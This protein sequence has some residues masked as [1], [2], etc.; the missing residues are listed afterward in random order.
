MLT[1]CCADAV[2]R[3]LDISFPFGSQTAIVG[4]S[5]AG[6]STVIALVSRFYDPDS[7]LIT[8]GGQDIHS[9]TRGEWARAVSLVS[10]EPVLFSGSSWQASAIHK[11]FHGPMVIVFAL[12]CQQFALSQ[13]LLHA[14]A[15]ALCARAHPHSPTSPPG[16]LARVISC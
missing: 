13:G 14:A 16:A 8:L 4:R 7:G 12:N 9:F 1:G 10:Q 6:K 2:L 3:G 5:G 15:S 11:Y